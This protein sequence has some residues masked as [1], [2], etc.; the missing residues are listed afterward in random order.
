MAQYK[1]SPNSGPVTYPDGS[2]RVLSDDELVVEGEEWAALA[3]L[4]FM[5]EVVEAPK[6]KKAEPVAPPAVEPEAPPVKVE[7][8]EELNVPEP[9][10][11]DGATASTV[12]PETAGGT[13]PE[14]GTGSRPSKRRR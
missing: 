2:D 7:P 11:N 8:E 13:D 14:S 3:A 9:Q 1:K 10:A 4:G 6:K 5:V 12:D